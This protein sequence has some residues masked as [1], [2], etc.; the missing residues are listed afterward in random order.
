MLV[1]AASAVVRLARRGRAARRL[2]RDV[3]GAT[4][5]EALM[6]HRSLRE[7]VESVVVV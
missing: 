6:H 4:G 5:V 3:E 7:V 2:L 1:L